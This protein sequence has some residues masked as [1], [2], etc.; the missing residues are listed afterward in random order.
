MTP[1]NSREKKTEDRQK[2]NYEEFEEVLEEIKEEDYDTIGL[3]GPDG[4]KPQLIDYAD[5]LEEH[6]FDTVII[7]ASTFG[8]CGI[9]DEKAERMGA[10]ALIHVGHTRFLHPE[11]QDMDD[12]NVYYLPYREDRDLMGVLRE[13]YEEIDAEK[14]G[15]VGVTQYMDRAE[16]ARE[17]LEDKGFEVVEGKTGLR[18]TEPGQVLGCDAGAAHN[19]AHKVDAFVFLGSGHFHPSQVSETGK[20]IYVVD[21]YEEHIWVEPANSLDDETR[22]EHARVIKHKDKK[23]WGI[24]TSSKKGQNYMQ[25]VQIAKEKLEKHG[26][27]VYVFVEDRI[28]E[29]DYKGFGI[30]IYVNCACP[31]MTKDWQDMAFVSPSALDV[32]NEVDIEHE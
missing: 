26:K 7:G 25:A 12:L 16:E 4:I 31:R 15:L 24:V 19:I 14:V 6:G 17:F 5:Q 9:A 21:P 1:K 29:P 8:A 2:F 20:D 22:A 10:D 13:H 32:L 30:D 27:D 23:K 18:T 28:F 11:R 3:Q